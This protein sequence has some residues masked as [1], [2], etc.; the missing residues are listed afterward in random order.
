M[1][2]ICTKYSFVLSLVVLVSSINIA[3]GVEMKEFQHTLKIVHDTCRT[4]TKVP[5]ETIQ[6]VRGD[7]YAD[8]AAMKCYVH[9]TME[10][11]HLMEGSVAQFH[12]AGKHTDYMIPQ[13][14][15]ETTIKAF[16]HCE[17]LTNGMTDNCEAAYAMLKC[18]REG[19][20]D[21]WLP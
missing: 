7:D 21:F 5:E 1:Q 6:Q 3:H 17:G 12:V 4:V 15:F 2:S 8:D 18:F 13:E 14:L 19:N 20:K 11:L 16:G 9:C 10:M